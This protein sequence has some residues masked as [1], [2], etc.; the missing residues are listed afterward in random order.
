MVTADNNN[1]IIKMQVNVW[2]TPRARNSTRTY[3]IFNTYNTTSKEFPA[4]HLFVMPMVVSSISLK[5]LSRAITVDHHP[6]DQR[7][8]VKH[9]NS[10]NL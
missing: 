3:P 4:P 7:G 6:C 10:I 2:T 9:V 8:H 5:L 1:N